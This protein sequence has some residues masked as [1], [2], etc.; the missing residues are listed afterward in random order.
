M[1]KLKTSDIPAF[2]RCLKAIGIK[3]E[4]ESITKKADNIKD[5]WAQGFELIY[6]IFDKAT[7]V[8]GEKELYKFLSGPFE[9]TAQEVENLEISVFFD[10]IKQLASENNLAGFFKS[11]AALK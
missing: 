4:I 1:R 11:A 5:A 3:S 2:C 6:N 7:E 9:M 8:N 10:M